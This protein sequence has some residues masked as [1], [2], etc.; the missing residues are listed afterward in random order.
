MPGFW[1]AFWPNLASSV[2]GCGRGHEHNAA[3]LD[4]LLNVLGEDKALLDLSLD[5]SPW[6][7]VQTDFSSDVDP[8]LRRRL[9]F[10]F[11]RLEAMVK[12]SDLY[13]SF[14]IGTNT[15]MSSAARRDLGSKR[16]H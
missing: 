1:D 14:I 10:H 9:A 6:G 13:L 12:L 5:T 3:Q 16:V 7:S 4:N 8:N 11:H 15:S 2:I